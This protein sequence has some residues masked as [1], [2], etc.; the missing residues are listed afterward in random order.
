MDSSLT[1]VRENFID[2]RHID[3]NSV[4]VDAGAC[5]GLFVEALRKNPEASKCKVIALECNVDNVNALI[6]QCLNDVKVVNRAL[7][8]QETPESVLFYHYIHCREWGNTIQENKRTRRR[9]KGIIKYMVKTVR[10]NGIFE[11]L[12]IDYID[13]LKM[14]IEGAEMEVL[15][16][17][18][19]KTASRIKQLFVEV[20][21][22][23]LKGTCPVFKKMLE[24]LGYE[25]QIIGIDAVY[26]IQRGSAIG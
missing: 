4:I 16:T 22:H 20:H 15:S 6:S 11:T 13:F 17:M 1:N 2:L 3:D 9:Y 7:V 10:I 5:V 8:G 21:K 23:P 24:R 14:D 25:A 18:T 19:Q 26:G 12:G